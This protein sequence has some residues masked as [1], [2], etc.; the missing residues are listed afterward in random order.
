MSKCQ[1]WATISSW[2]TKNKK[3][4]L[5]QNLSWIAFSIMSKVMSISYLQNQ[6]FLWIK[7][8]VVANYKSLILLAGQYENDNH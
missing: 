3:G 6:G 1:I 5:N 2:S 8:Q 7:F 4:I